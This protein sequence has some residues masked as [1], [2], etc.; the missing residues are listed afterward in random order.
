MAH[1]EDIL[2][3]SGLSRRKEN[4]FKNQKHRNIM[5]TETETYNVDWFINFYEAI[6]EDRWC[7]NT[8]HYEEKSCAMGHL[9][10][11]FQCN[12]V[13]NAINHLFISY[14]GCLVPMVNDYRQVEVEFNQP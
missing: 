9:A 4:N 11:W 1:Q 10:K 14:L 6:P 7:T 2:R 3:G 13:L 8:L 12:S 5:K